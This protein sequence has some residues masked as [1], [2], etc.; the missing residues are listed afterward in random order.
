MTLKEIARYLGGDLIG[1]PD[2]DI[3]RPAKIE[4]ADEGEIT[5]IANPKYIKF[6]SQTAA[7]AV[8]VDSNVKDVNLPHIRVE[9]AYLG[10]LQLL[11]LFKP[12]S[13]DYFSG[14]SDKAFVDPTAII[15][16][17][18]NIAPL[19]YIGPNVKIG[20]KTI[21]YPGVVLL[22]NVNIGSECV[23]YPNVSVREECQIGSRVILHNGCV[24]GSDGFG[25][26]PEGEAYKKIPQLG[27]VVI[28]DDVEI[29]ANVTID[30]ATI[31]DTKIESG[32]KLDNLVHV[33]HNVLI[34]E[35]AAIAAQSGI[36]GSSEL[37]KKVTM[38]GQVG[39]AGHLKIGDHSMIAAQSGV[40][41]SVPEKSVLFGTPALPIMQQ[42]RMDVSVRKLPDLI[43]KVHQMEK[44]LEELKNFINELKMRGTDD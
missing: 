7:S 6:L 5:F 36:S 15:G 30:R 32:C 29:G 41:K 39:V 4:F 43:K 28:Q 23:V 1:P 26:A 11:E 10:F 12:K 37:G 13:H 17:G 27:R 19:A 16:E 34:G 20:S 31:G 9:N 18:V 25:F 24:I 44:E 8:I 21:I 42:K 38:G 3:V 35:D 2:I 22:K 40:S 33:A 14:I